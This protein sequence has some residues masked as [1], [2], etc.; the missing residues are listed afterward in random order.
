MDHAQFDVPDEQSIYLKSSGTM[1]IR[2]FFLAEHLNF[3]VLKMGVF[4]GM[5][6]CMPVASL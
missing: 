6:I 5:M 2:H 3:F 1:E 4:F